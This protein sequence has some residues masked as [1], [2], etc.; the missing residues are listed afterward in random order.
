MKN[1]QRK[2]QNG[3]GDQSFRFSFF[4]PRFPFLVRADRTADER[5]CRL[6]RRLHRNTSGATSTEYM[7]ILVF[8]VIPIALMMPMIMGMVRTYGG[9]MTSLMGLPFP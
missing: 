2:M 3:E 7:L 8:V 4:I 1:R 5:L 6:L 9:R